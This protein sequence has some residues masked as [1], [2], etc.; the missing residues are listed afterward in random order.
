MT[1]DTRPRP[2]PI[3][4]IGILGGMSDKAT[5]EYYRLVNAKINERLGGWDNGEIVIVSV[6]FGNIQH[7]VRNGLWDAARA[8]LDDKLDR[9][10]AAGAE[11]IVCGSNTMHRVVEPAM[12]TR[13]T[14]FIHIADPTARAIRAAGLSKVALLGTYPVMAGPEFVTRYR[15]RF[16]IEALVP[17]E[18]AKRLVDRIIFDELVK[19][20][21]R[22]ESLE[23]YRGVIADLAA[24]GA[25]GVILG[26]TEIYMLT[27]RGHLDGLPL[28]DTTELI[29]DALV[30][31]ALGGDEAVAPVA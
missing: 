20:I 8:Y 7:F 23:A 26:C 2:L 17:D 27:G 13:R 5:G 25:E 6:N 3:R 1:D 24:R 29:V 18:E 22:P 9:L 11:V 14:P 30:D 16:G 4:T 21:V 15:E 28:F 10:E 31:F 19:D 12:A